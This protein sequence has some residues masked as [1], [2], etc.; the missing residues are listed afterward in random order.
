MQSYKNNTI[1]SAV[2]H[3]ERPQGISRVWFNFVVDDIAELFYLDDIRWYPLLSTK[4]ICLGL[5]DQKSL[6][7]AAH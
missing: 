7:Y 3:K 5:L 1:Q 4:L 2:C 6:I